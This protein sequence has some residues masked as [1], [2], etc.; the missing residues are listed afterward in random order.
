MTFSK[1]YI[2]K[3]PNIHGI[4]PYTP[5]ENTTW[6]MLFT[7]QS[8]I[9][10][11][12]ACDEFIKGITLLNLSSSHIPQCP[13]MNKILQSLT[14]W[15]V[16]PVEAI[17]P[18]EEFFT[19]LANRT[20]PAAS[21]I[22]RCEELDY[23]TEPDI[24]HEFFGHCPLLTDQAYADFMYDYGK[25]ALQAN[26]IDRTYLARLYWFTIEFGLINSAHGSRVYGGGIL[27]SKEETVYAIDSPI[28]QRLALGDGLAALRTP[29]RIDILQPIYY[30][31]EKYQDLYNL[32]QGDIIGLIHKAQDLG[33][34]APLFDTNGAISY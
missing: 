19:L 28:P 5:E 11:D 20:F 29:Y 21:F 1:K 8:N 4:I 3:K 15:S 27:S 31:L 14:G 34:F 7:R 10:I 23:L 32:M 24:F 13:E 33:D 18:A 9:V 12:R 22:R 16:Q 30:V 25:K 26:D 6:Q 17:I 2:A